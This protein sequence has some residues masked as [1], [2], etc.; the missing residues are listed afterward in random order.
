METNGLRVVGGSNLTDLEKVKIERDNYAKKFDELQQQMKEMGVIGYSALKKERD[1]LKLKNTELEKSLAVINGQVSYIKENF[2]LKVDA[3]V[4]KRVTNIKAEAER[5]RKENSGLKSG[6]IHGPEGRVQK[7]LEREDEAKRREE[8]AIRERDKLATQLV[9]MEKKLDSM[10][11]DLSINKELLIKAETTIEMLEDQRADLRQILSNTNIVKDKI[12][13]IGTE[14]TSGK[15]NSIPG[16][17]SIFDNKEDALYKITILI[18]VAVCKIERDKK[19]DMTVARAVGLRDA[20][21]VEAKIK[22]HR[23]NGVYD[24]IE[25]YVRDGYTISKELRDKCEENS[26]YDYSGLLEILDNKEY[27]SYKIV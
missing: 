17:K 18:E 8:I 26:E 7:A 12:D 2:S 10:A 4:N 16:L 9:N 22:K 3:E 14:V 11:E 25:A 21:Y 6:H 23:N 27:A 24:I 5:L 20:N 15:I 1:E 19:C 13:N